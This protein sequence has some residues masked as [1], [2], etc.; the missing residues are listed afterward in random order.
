MNLLYCVSVF[1]IDMPTTEWTHLEGMN[2]YLQYVL[3]LFVNNKIPLIK[4]LKYTNIAL[5]CFCITLML[6]FY[7]GRQGIHHCKLSITS[8]TFVC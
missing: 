7:M 8:L 4:C 3:P 6:G 2:F 1:K 5:K